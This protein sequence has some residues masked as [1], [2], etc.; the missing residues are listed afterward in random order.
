MG[1]AV[2]VFVWLNV[3]LLR[4]IHA[5]VHIPYDLDR[6]FAS[7]LV[8][9]SLSIFW[10]VIGLAGTILGNRTESRKTWIYAAGL[11]GVVVIK[12]FSIDL[13]NSSSIERIVS[14][15]VVGI[16]LLTVG[17]FSPLPATESAQNDK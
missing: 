17:Y 14:F 5:W 9:T 15:L 3:M 4:S 8:Q 12:L 11:I 6:M 10:T 2:F 7:N 16:L 13:A 1:L